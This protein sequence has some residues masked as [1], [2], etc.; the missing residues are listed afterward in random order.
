MKYDELEKKIREVFEGFELQGVKSEFITTKWD[1]STL[2]KFG[3][4]RD[5]ESWTEITISG[6]VKEEVK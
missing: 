4:T 2:E 6:I 5:N 1:N 3:V